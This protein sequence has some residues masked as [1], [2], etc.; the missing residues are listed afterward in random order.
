MSRHEDIIFIFDNW[1]SGL[2]GNIELLVHCIISSFNVSCMHC[3][4]RVCENNKCPYTIKKIQFL[5]IYHMISENRSIFG[6]ERSIGKKVQINIPRRQ[7]LA[8][9]IQRHYKFCSHSILP[10][11]IANHGPWRLFMLQPNWTSNRKPPE[12]PQGDNSNL[13]LEQNCLTRGD[14]K[15]SF[16]TIF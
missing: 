1:S 16:L 3:K 2:S 12:W 8:W 9:K 15:S 14:Y 10:S 13:I 5:E 11:C 6:I 7:S 4:I